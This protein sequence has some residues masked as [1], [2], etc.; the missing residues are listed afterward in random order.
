MASNWQYEKMG[1]FGS[2]RDAEDW[3]R[4]NNVDLRDIRTPK[5]GEGVELEI[6]RSAAE[7]DDFD[8]RDRGFGRREGF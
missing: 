6:R 7:P 5:S 2:A 1:R 4:R 8:H 3:C